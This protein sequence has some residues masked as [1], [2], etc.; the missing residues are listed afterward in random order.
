MNNF[1]IDDKTKK[2]IAF[3]KEAIKDSSF[4]GNIF[5][6]GET[7]LN[8]LL[9]KPTKTI[10]IFVQSPNGGIA[11]ANILAYAD[12]SFKENQNPQ[13]YDDGQLIKLELT[14]FPDFNFVIYESLQI[15]KDEVSMETVYKT[16]KEDASIRNITINSIYYNITT[17]TFEDP[18]GYGITDFKN[19]L[20]RCASP[21]KY[22]YESPIRVLQ[23][24]RI[25][26][27]L[28]FGIE[29][30]TWLKMLKYSSKIINAQKSMVTLEI[31]KLLT[32]DKP[33][34]GIRKMAVC[35]NLL[36]LVLPDIYKEQFVME[37]IKTTVFDH[38]MKVVDMVKPIFVNRIAA[39]FHA[40]AKNGS[41]KGMLASEIA[42]KAK[43]IMTSMGIPYNTAM[44]ASMA[45]G[46]QNTFATYTAKEIPKK[47][48]L[49]SFKS[50][51]GNDFDLAMD[52]MN[53]I[54]TCRTFGAKP[55][56]VQMIINK[57]K[58]IELKE[59]KIKPTIKLPVNGNDL[60]KNF[61]IATGP[62]VGRLLKMIKK[63]YIK[64]P[65]LTKDDCF[66]LVSDA[67]K[68]KSK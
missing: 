17:D 4:E 26:C 2:L 65:S 31:A 56:Q 51:I 28:G 62:V 60:M 64:N 46:V 6:T 35:N 49:K 43:S 44:S 45:I 41:A 59:K 54:N 20:L 8:W 63:E 13:T 10:E 55:K 32:T 9:G 29:K 12:E 40:V 15:K 39:L 7:V 3:I 14:N 52:L 5:F 33:S 58:D 27:A 19:K 53:A 24:I 61:S 11:F 16:I 1:I 57:L 47:S 25:S 66:D 34:I 38:T 37:D 48:L 30:N 36:Q 67:I 50:F 21:E 22:F 68:S 23:L 18:S 42:S